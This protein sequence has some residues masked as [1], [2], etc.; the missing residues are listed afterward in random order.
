MKSF[1]VSDPSLA[2]TL[3]YQ[4]MLKAYELCGTELGMGIFQ[5]VPSMTLDSIPK[6][7]SVSEDRLADMTS[8]YA[9]YLAGRMVKTSIGYSE[10][11]FIYLPDKKPNP[12]YQGWSAGTP[13]DP[14]VLRGYVAN[15]EKPRSY[16]ELLNLA[17]SE[18]GVTVQPC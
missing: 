12:D 3:A 11:G 8:L 13:G 10:N 2:K 9:D 15:L 16:E 7:L 1:S 4:F 14:G 5:A 18:I 6:Y 17:A